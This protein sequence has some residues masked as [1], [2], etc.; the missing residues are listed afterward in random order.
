MGDGVNWVETTHKVLYFMVFISAHPLC[1]PS[2]TRL[3]RLE[4]AKATTKTEALGELMG[5]AR[6][7]TDWH[8]KKKESLNRCAPLERTQIQNR[9]FMI[10]GAFKDLHDFF[11]QIAPADL[12]H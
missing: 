10:F 1:G 4:K 2:F 9:R 12:S 8:H 3:V 6:I 7:G 5:W 11:E